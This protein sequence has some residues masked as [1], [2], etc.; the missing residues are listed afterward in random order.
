MTHSI[1]NNLAGW[2][3][4]ELAEMLPRAFRARLRRR[5]QRLLVD[6]D[7][8]LASFTV[9]EGPREQRIL[10][11]DF[12]VN[13]VPAAEAADDIKKACGGRVRDIV[14]RV[15]AQHALRRTLA[16]PLAA[17]RNLRAVLGFEMDRYTP[18]KA[19]L[20]YYDF[21]VL[22]RDE[23]NL[24]VALTVV[25]RKLVDPLLG[26]LRRW[27]LE[28]SA[29]EAGDRTNLLPAAQRGNARGSA[30]WANKALAGCAALLLVA[31]L[32][33]PFVQKAQSVARL[34]QEL[35]DVRKE[36]LAAEQARKALEQL[37]AEE[38]ALVQRRRQRP[39]AIQVVQEITRLLPDSTWLNQLELT[40]TRVK[41]RG[42]SSNASE[43]VTSIE[44]S[45][46]FKGAA[47]DGSVTRDPRTERER[48]AI[49]ATAQPQEKR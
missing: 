32:A 23:R 48:F 24:Q 46:V 33:L 7:G 1:L 16:M 40:G 49:S 35:E 4:S 38:N 12:R 13:A 21:A 19:E 30:G 15:A 10:E 27:G 45:G 17:E 14:V 47:F 29:L 44:K 28:A 42:E 22:G 3:V 11:V 36:A 31:A 37:A 20:V 43:L 9:C 25:A 2:W 6:F 8:E 41:I 18:F 26:L 5:A 39:A 34:E